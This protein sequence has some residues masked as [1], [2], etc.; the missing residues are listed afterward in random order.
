MPAK[1]LTMGSGYAD[2]RE[3][4]FFKWKRVVMV[5]DHAR[6]GES[7]LVSKMDFAK[8]KSLGL[9]VSKRSLNELRNDVLHKNLENVGAGDPACLVGQE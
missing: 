1:Q 7:K 4:I 6:N 5:R 9:K 3:S 2:R 8:P